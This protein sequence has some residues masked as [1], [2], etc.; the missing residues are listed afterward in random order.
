MAVRAAQFAPF[1]AVSGHDAAIRKEGKK[2][3]EEYE[4]AED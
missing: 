4:H 2:H 3:I 1:A